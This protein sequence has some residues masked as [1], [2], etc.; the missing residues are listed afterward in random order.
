MKI[1]NLLSGGPA[2]NWPTDI[3]SQF[4]QG[5]A[6]GIDRGALSLLKMGISPRAA[7]GDFDSVSASEFQQ[8]QNQIK[9]IFRSEPI[10]DETDTELALQFAAQ[11]YQPDRFR[12]FGF[13]GGRLDQLLTNLLM[14]YKPAI[15][16]LAN[17][18]ELIDRQNWGR[19]YLPGTHQITKVPG[20]K[21][22]DFVALEPLVLSLPDEKY[23]LDS[24]S[25]KHPTSF[26]SNEF[27]TNQASFTFD[28]GIMLVLQSCD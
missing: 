12:L 13:S 22:L 21:Y 3:A 18:L 7:V 11:T 4:Q 15:R 5:V 19:F 9:T 1:V 24:F 8:L 17:R 26:S 28:R 25:V 6:V 2:A 23:Q 27:L 14:V 10:K 20:M 16:P